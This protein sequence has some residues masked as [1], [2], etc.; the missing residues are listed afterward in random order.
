MRRLV[1]HPP[2]YEASRRVVCFDLHPN[3]R[4]AHPL[5]GSTALLATSSPARPAFF[6]DIRPTIAV[7]KRWRKAFHFEGNTLGQRRHE[8]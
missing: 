2:F 6:P 1:A 3:H 4:T 5:P 8:Q 7:V